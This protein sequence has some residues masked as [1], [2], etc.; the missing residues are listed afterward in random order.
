MPLE[1]KDNVEQ[2]LP[3][4]F[5]EKEKTYELWESLEVFEYY[6]PND[7]YSVIFDY[8]NERII[9]LPGV[10]VSQILYE[11]EQQVLDEIVEKHGEFSDD[12]IEY[13]YCVEVFYPDY[14]SATSDNHSI[15][16]NGYWDNLEI[17][18]YRPTVISSRMKIEKVKI[19]VPVWVSIGSKYGTKI[20][21]VCPNAILDAMAK[22]LNLRLE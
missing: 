10:K 1:E 11:I 20:V 7:V 9:I 13:N 19:K 22:S 6:Y 4:N 3:S 2:Y 17:E 15:S 8:Y 14:W 21:S 18:F 5:I 16:S 12:Q